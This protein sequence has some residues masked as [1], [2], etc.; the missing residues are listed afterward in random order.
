MRKSNRLVQKLAFD[1]LLTELPVP[2]AEVDQKLA[3]RIADAY[4]AAVHQP[5]DDNVKLAYRRFIEETLK[6]FVR[7]KRW[8]TFEPWV[9]SGQP[10]ANSEAMRRDIYRKRHLFFFRGGEWLP[11]HPMAEMSPFQ[12]NGLDLTNN[13]IFRAVHDLYGHGRYNFEF[14][15]RGEE[16]A[17]LSHSGMY[18]SVAQEALATETRGQN[19]WIN[20]GRHLRRA[21]G[22]VPVKGDVDFVPSHRRPYAEQKA[23]ILPAW[24]REI[25]AR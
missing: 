10:Y 19:S 11:S 14:G 17:W 20:F 25:H 18:T 15:A 23:V 5:H 22:T 24:C 8:I 16:N 12:I 13:D 6:Q 21:D 4:D 9:D 7:A 1:Y 2:Y 3:V